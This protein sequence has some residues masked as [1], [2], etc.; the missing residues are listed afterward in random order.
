M[1]FSFLAMWRRQNG[2]LRASGS[3]KVS[4]PLKPEVYNL[5]APE[6]S[7]LKILMN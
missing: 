7:G 4:L 5:A 6:R 2:S 3:R 1:S